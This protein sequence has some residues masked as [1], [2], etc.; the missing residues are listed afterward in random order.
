MKHFKL[1][2]FKFRKKMAKVEKFNTRFFEINNAMKKLT[3]MIFK[4]SNILLILKKINKVL[5]YETFHINIY[6]FNL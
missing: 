5:C 1:T 4:I 2:I 3:Y 6:K